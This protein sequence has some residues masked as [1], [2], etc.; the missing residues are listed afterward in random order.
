[1]PIG[2][3]L[4]RLIKDA[5]Q[6]FWS[7]KVDDDG[8]AYGVHS[9]TDDAIK[10]FEPASLPFALQELWSAPE[11]G[12]IDTGFVDASRSVQE[13]LRSVLEAYIVTALL[14]DKRLASENRLRI[15]RINA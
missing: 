7:T 10:S 4:Q 14:T 12:F 3:H 11:V 5:A 8:S 1:M 6:R 15:E 2:A 9:A 13:I